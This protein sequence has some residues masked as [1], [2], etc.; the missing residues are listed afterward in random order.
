MTDASPAP[1]SLIRELIDILREQSPQDIASLMKLSDKL[2]G[3][4][5]SRFQEWQPPFTPDNATQAVLAFPGDVYQGMAA[6]SFSEEDFER[7]QHKLRILSGL[8][9]LLRPLDL[10]QP[11]RLEMGTRLSNPAGK[12]LYACDRG[13]V[14]ITRPVTTV[15]VTS[16]DA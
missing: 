15:T 13:V 1:G 10:I 3:L 6:D 16:H 5:A 2:A 9:G 12:D 7:A 8:Y 4:N 11:Y 14:C